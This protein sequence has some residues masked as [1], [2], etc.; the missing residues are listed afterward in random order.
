MDISS[1]LRVIQLKTS[2]KYRIHRTI[3]IIVVPLILLSTATGVF[4][5]NQKWYWEAGYKKKKQPS[6]FSIDKAFVSI[7]SL[8]RKIDSI[9]GKKNQYEKINVKQENKNVYYELL[10][11]S[12][13]K[14]LAEAYTGKIVS[15][16]SSELAS[17]FAVQYVKEKSPVKSCELLKEYV[18]RKSKEIKPAY[19]V[20]FDNSVHS[21]IY[22]DYY[23]GEIIEDIDD[24]RKFGMWIVRL[25]DYDF[26][27][28]KRLLTTVIG[29]SIVLLS[30]SG[31]WIYRI[32]LKK[33]TES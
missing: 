24:N 5:A 26:F 9:S 20:E 19:R 32:R 12:K 25:H 11:A 23:T 27:D 3:G 17:D 30:F 31:L 22:L 8:T 28:S 6:D 7:N 10:T 2:S 18:P 21:E 14:Y 15:P 33:R 1:D 13:E 29:I 16:L 4:R